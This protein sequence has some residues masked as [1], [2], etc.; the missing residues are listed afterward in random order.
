MEDDQLLQQLRHEMSVE[1]DRTT[2]ISQDKREKIIDA[3]FT[4]LQ[5]RSILANYDGPDE[6]DLPL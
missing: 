1:I 3:V 5:R 4:V 6:E 2:F